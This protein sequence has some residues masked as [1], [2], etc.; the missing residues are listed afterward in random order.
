MDLEAFMFPLT[1]GE[2]NALLCAECGMR[3]AVEQIIAI[4]QVSLQFPW[5]LP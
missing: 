4:L 5:T 1:V 3:P 2:I